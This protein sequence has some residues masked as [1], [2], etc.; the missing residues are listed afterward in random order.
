MS[1]SFE[2]SYSHGKEKIH[3]LYITKNLSVRTKLKKNL[4]FSRSYI[5]VRMS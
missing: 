3:Y 5:W 2:L 4:V 1:L